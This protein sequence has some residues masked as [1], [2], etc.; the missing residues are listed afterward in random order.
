M[1]SKWAIKATPVILVLLACSGARAQSGSAAAPPGNA[2]YEH[3]R[4][5]PLPFDAIGFVAFEHGLG[6][7]TVTGAPFSA[8]F[9][10]QMSQTLS[11]GNRI[12]HSTTGTM[13]R[14]SQGR[15][16]RDMTLPA[17][18]PFAT[19]GGAPPHAVFINDP[20]AGVHYV[21]HP[22][23]KT[24]NKL[25]PHRF[26]SRDQKGGWNHNENGVTKVSLG[27]QMIAGVSAEGTRT[28]RTIPAGAMGNE[29]PIQIV[30]ERWF[31]P[32]LQINVLTKRSDPFRGDTVVQLTN[33]QRQEPDASLFQVPSDYSVQEGRGHAPR[34]SQPEP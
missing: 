18:G 31:S 25:T 1:N 4:P 11:D 3:L 26:G 6:G 19:S 20:V 33:I 10:T 21:L 34:M 5:G 8:G 2:V 32:D 14:D 24:A 12:Q 15:T 17:I 9:S 7:K 28:M 29:K 13:A 22:E 27:T 16:R 23:Q 30:T